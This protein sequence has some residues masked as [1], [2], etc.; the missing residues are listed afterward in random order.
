MRVWGDGLPPALHGLGDADLASGAD[1]GSAESGV[2]NV[3]GV[4]DTDVGAVDVKDAREAENG[5]YGDD[6][7]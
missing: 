1:T 3:K 2:L 5:V 4:F 6:F 7:T